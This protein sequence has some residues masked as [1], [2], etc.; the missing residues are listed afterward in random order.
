MD[1]KRWVRTG[2]RG[3]RINEGM[4]KEEENERWEGVRVKGGWK[5]RGEG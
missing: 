2:C 3:G 4:G 1:V 5:K